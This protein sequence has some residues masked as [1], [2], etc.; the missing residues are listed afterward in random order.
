MI[1]LPIPALIGVVHLPPLPGSATSRLTIEDIVEHAL[2]DAATLEEAGFDAL[3]VENFGDAPFMA[4]SLPPG[5]VAAMAVVADRIRSK[6]SCAV[7]IN[8]LRND[9]QAA[10]GIAAATGAAFVR[11]NVHVGV[12]ATDQGLIEGRADASMRYRKLLA[13]EVAILADVHVK[14]AMPL[15]QP[16]IAEAARDVAYRGLADGLIVTGVRTGGAVA[17][18]DLDAVRAAVPDRPLYIG[19]GATP[20]TIGALLKHADGVIVGCGI[21]QGGDPA[22]AIDAKLA[23]AFVKA[24]KR[25]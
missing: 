17:E 21:K 12:Y 5:C 22:K 18:D 8:C 25:G 2:R 3:I 11:I 10:I 23:G 14:H 13:S 9:A 6:V 24:A 19:S 16:D 20:Q 4:K 1:D 7:G 15:S